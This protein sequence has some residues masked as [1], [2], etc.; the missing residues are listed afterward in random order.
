MRV[1]WARK[2]ER[3]HD[4]MSFRRRFFIS[5][6]FFLQRPSLCLFPAPERMSEF[7]QSCP[8]KMTLIVP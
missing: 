1:L 8:L 5:Y 4:L 3:Y 6:V 2:L 7:P